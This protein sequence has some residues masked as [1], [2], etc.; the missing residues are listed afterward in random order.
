MFI[1]F[2]FSFKAHSIDV[3]NG[4]DGICNQVTIAAN[5]KNY[6]QCTSLV[7][8]GPLNVFKAGGA[9]A[10]VGT[11]V[12]KVQN[13]VTIGAGGTIDLS[14]ADGENGNTALPITGG[15]AGAG[16]GAG[17]NSAATNG[18]NGNGLG[19]GTGGSLATIT[20][21]TPYG[22]G[23]GG[24]SYGAVDVITANSGTGDS[25]GVAGANGATYFPE[26]NFET[27]FTGGS[28]GGAGGTGVDSSGP[29]SSYGSSGG[30]GGGAIR[31]VAG[32]D[33]T[34]AGSIISN[35]G[36]GGGIAATISSGGGGGGSGGAIWLQAAGA[37]DIAGTTSLTGGARGITDDAVFSYGFGG[38][39]GKGRIRLDDADGIITGAGVDPAAYSTTFTPTAITSGATR[40]YTSAVACG[41]IS[42]DDQKPFNNLINLIL[43]M[44]LATLVYFSILRKGKV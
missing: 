42:L 9:G 29:T 14:G 43:G 31:I 12:I 21:G 30:G 39:G 23:G 5:P 25:G 38:R 3:G 41:R 8:N 22:G 34:I 20:V 11:V 33:I 27:S 35:G 44:L 6:Y 10:N 17:G 7:I 37:I 28:G 16:G 13:D 4:L 24:G 19:K 32:G 18:S 26:S 36:A 1:L 40:Q 2:L 15:A